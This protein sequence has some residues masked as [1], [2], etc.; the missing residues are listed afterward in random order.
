MCQLDTLVREELIPK[1]DVVKI[2]VEGGERDILVGAE[3]TIR[4]HRPAL[5]YEAIASLTRRFGYEPSDLIAL[6]ASYGDYEFFGIRGNGELISVGQLGD[7]SDVRDVVA[8]P[9][10]HELRL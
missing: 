5:V 4:T 6:I 10:S 1:P 9:P 8:V 2:D 3:E 7:E